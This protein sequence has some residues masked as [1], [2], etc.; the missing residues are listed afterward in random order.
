MLHSDICPIPSPTSAHHKHNH[1]KIIY[2]NV[3]RK[4]TPTRAGT[5][6]HRHCRPSS[7]RLSTRRPS[8]GAS[9]LSLSRVFR[10]L[11]CSSDSGSKTDGYHNR[12][13]KQKRLARCW[14]D[15]SAGALSAR[16]GV[17][18]LERDVQS[19]AGG[20]SAGHCLPTGC[21]NQNRS[22]RPK[23]TFKREG[24]L[25]VLRR[26]DRCRVEDAPLASG[27]SPR[28]PVHAWLMRAEGTSR[29]GVSRSPS[30]AS[31]SS[32]PRPQTP[33]RS[34]PRTASCLAGS[35]PP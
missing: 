25:N 12:K 24:G 34:R 19:A 35:P 14:S 30:A 9:A 27:D 6:A 11:R 26:E 8:D 20:D 28:R 29:R 1:G 22:Y 4:H 13:Q 31:P 17:G 10:E 18:C 5:I 3:Y 23:G 21:W 32:Q 16:P 2:S 33:K 7:L 15:D